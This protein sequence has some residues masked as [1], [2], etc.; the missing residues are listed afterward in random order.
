MVDLGEVTD[1]P[2]PAGGGVETEASITEGPQGPWGPSYF[3]R[4]QREA[5]LRGLPGGRWSK[6]ILKIANNNRS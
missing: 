5:I 4:A 3:P 6:I 1:S 2:A